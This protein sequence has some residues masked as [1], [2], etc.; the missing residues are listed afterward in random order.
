MHTVP[1]A[2]I[3]HESNIIG[4]LTS[5]RGS[6][7]PAYHYN[8]KA[9]WYLVYAVDVFESLFARVHTISTSKQSAVEVR[10]MHVCILSQPQ[11]NYC[12]C[13]GSWKRAH[14]QIV[15]TSKQC[16]ACAVE[17]RTMHVCITS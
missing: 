7:T 5:H 1:A 10:S 8:L 3:K 4:L 12:L 13:I 11:S 16:T 14:V 9:V 15:T 2:N 6:T 17:V